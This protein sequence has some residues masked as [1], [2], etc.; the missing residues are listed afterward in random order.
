MS[1]H[2]FGGREQEISILRQLKILVAVLIISNIALGVFGFSFLRT[3]DRKY[4]ALI[5]RAVPTMNDLQELTTVAEAAMRGTNP[6]LFGDS[7]QTRTETSQR[8]HNAVDRDRNLRNS[9]LQREWLFKN[10]EERMNFH[11]L[12][13]AFSRTAEKIIGLLESAENAEAGRQREELLR[14]AFERY[15]AATAKAANVLEAQSLK[16]SN[17][18]TAKTG[19]MSNM[20]IG[21]A[22]WPLIT[23]GIFFFVTA[24]FVIVVLLNVFFRNSEAM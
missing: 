15:I 18:L 24:V 21:F 10:V 6:I 5:D 2:I 12:G 14:P 11:N 13:E 22:S 20:M 3:L 16:T 23:L 1:N 19:S 7:S 4:S 9:I 17:A 8:G